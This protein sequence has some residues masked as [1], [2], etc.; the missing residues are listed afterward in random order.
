MLRTDGLGLTEGEK[1]DLGS[2]ERRKEGVK[3]GTSEGRNAKGDGER[4]TVFH[5]LSKCGGRGIRYEH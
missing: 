2:D 4:L 5:S 1:E 3:L